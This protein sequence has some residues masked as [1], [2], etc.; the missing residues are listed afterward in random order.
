MV[1][2]ASPPPPDVIC[3][4]A[5]D[6]SYST[7]P[8]PHNLWNSTVHSVLTTAHR[9]FP[10]LQQINPVDTPP[11]YFLNISFSIILLSTSRSSK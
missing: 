11:L 9:L 1:D 5:C 3:Q 10:S 6:Y 2:F 4:V 8:T 7:S